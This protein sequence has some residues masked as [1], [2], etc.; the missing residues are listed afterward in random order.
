MQHKEPKLRGRMDTKHKKLE[1]YKPGATQ[2]QVFKALKKVAK[3]PK[4]SE[5]PS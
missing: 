5:K 2:T 3:A 1:D 4:P